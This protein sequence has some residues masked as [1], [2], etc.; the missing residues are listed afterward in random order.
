MSSYSVRRPTG[1]RSVS[2]QIPYA[3]RSDC[4]RCPI[5]LRTQ[6]GRKLYGD[7]LKSLGRTTPNL[8]QSHQKP[9]ANLQKTPR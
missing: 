4:V 7:E 6:N 1:S 3:A 5:G 8:R 9:R 2:D